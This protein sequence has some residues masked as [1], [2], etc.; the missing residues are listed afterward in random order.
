[1]RFILSCFCFIHL[2][3]A[4]TQ[5]KWVLL[6]KTNMDSTAIWDTDGL[7]QCYV[8]QRQNIQKLSASGKLMLEESNKSYGDIEKIDALNPLKIAFFSESQQRICFLDNALAL[9]QNCINLSDLDVNLGTTISS[10]GQTDRI[11][12]YDEPNQRIELVTLR[13]NQSQIIQNINRLLGFD[14]I[15][16]IQEINN[17]LYVF[18]DKHQ[19]AWLDQYGNFIDALTLPSFGAA[20]PIQDYILFSEDKKIQAIHTVTEDK[21]L[22][23]DQDL[24]DSSIIKF[25][26]FANL[27]FIQT[28]TT[29]YC[30][31]L[32]KNE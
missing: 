16:N 27:I 3:I 23:F 26:T 30:F 7:S 11:W 31:T 9:Q 15:I 1:M 12:I 10:S 6:W 28:K 25:K 20:Y 19:I 29:L 32:K 22:F 21:Q 5:E 18:D 17:L 4:F 2:S 13:N 24:I 14:H 8:F